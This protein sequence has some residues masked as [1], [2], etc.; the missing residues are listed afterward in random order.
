LPEGVIQGD[1]QHRN[2]LHAGEVEA[3]RDRDTVAVGQ[4]KW[5]LVTVEVR[6]RR[7]GRGQ[8]N[9]AAFTDAYG[10]DVTR[11]PGYRTL[12]ASRG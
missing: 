1:P 3:V 7:F 12:A 6:C 8:Q 2:A 11:R 5:D 10:R 9:Y 4:P